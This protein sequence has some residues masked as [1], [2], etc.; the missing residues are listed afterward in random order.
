[1]GRRTA[2]WLGWLLAAALLVFFENN[3]GTRAVWVI[4]LAI[5]LFSMACAWQA[6]RRLSVSLRAPEQAG[7]G[8]RIRCEA[9]VPASLWLAGC[10]AKCGIS[11]YNGLTGE[12]LEGE[13]VFTR[14]GTGTAEAESSRCGRIRIRAEWAET[15]DWFGICRFRREAGAE[16]YVTVTPELIPVTLRTETEAGIRPGAQGMSRRS[17]ADPEPGSLRPYVPGDDIRRI[18][19]KL[20]EKTDQTLVMESAPEARE[21]T[22]LALETAYPEKADPEAAHDAARGLLSLSRAMTEAGMPHAVITARN[23]EIWIT[24]TADEAGARQAAEEVLSA[25]AEPGGVSIGTLLARTETRF[26][27]VILFSPHPYA[28]AA[29]AAERQPVTL[30][31]PD[32]VPCP[33]PEAGIRTAVFTSGDA[34][35]EI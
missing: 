16:T 7:A 10:T 21:I 11:V 33:G 8:D 2:A 22:A 20:S 1:M 12:T 17:A 26:R 9:A 32:Y 25:E 34:E 31:L 29:A 19:W 23:G 35:I 30:V 28:A 4:S 5:P 27:R 13:I 24:E 6:V 15:R 18:H 14:K 3:T